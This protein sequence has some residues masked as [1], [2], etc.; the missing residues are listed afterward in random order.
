MG[1]C[2]EASALVYEYLANGNLEDRLNC[3]G[4]TPFLTWQLRTKIIGEVCSALIFLHSAKPHP[5]VHGDLKPENILLDSNNVSKISDFGIARLLQISSRTSVFHR[6]NPKGTN[7]YIDPEFM[8]TG[9]LTP[10]SDVYSLG[11]L[12]LR[13]LTGK[14][15]WKIAQYVE[16]ASDND[17]R[18]MIDRS[19]GS[20]PFVQAR[21]LAYIGVRCTNVSR[22]RRPDLIK[23]VWPVIE[24]LVKATV[25]STSRCCDS[26]ADESH[27]PSYFIC[28]IVQVKYDPVSLYIMLDVFDVT[29]YFSSSVLF[30]GDLFSQVV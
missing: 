22:K 27:T 17:F 11:I 3:R 21:K 9:E 5:I 2:P 7:G 20:W 10:Q 12:I 26:I 19:A 24:P 15:V 8:T 6:T 13:L 18:A 30:F 23:D 28:P 14:P 25:A 4:N 1:S 16:A 29:L